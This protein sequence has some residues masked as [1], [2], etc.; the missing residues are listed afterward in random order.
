MAQLIDLEGLPEP[1]A[2]AIAETVRNLK[3][4]YSVKETSPSEDAHLGTSYDADLALEALLDTLPAMPSLSDEAVS[5][6]NIYAV[7][8]EI[9]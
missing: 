1:V 4:G 2:K 7:D 5:R 9:R 8:E 3:C 6:E